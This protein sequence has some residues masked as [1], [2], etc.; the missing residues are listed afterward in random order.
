MKPIKVDLSGEFKKIEIHPLADLHIGDTHC[1]FK[2]ILDELEYI[3]KTPN[4]YCILD[5]DLMNTAIKNSVSDCYSESISPMEQIKHC[6]SIFEPIK[7][8]ILAVC[9][10]NHEARVYRETSLDMTELFCSQLGIVDRYSSSTAL[11][12]IRFGKDIKHNRKMCYT[13]YMTHGNGGG[14]KE[15]GKINRLADLANI[16]DA[17]IYVMAHTH[18]PAAFRNT[19]YRADPRNSDVTNCEH[20]FVNTASW[21]EYSG[22][23]GDTMGFKPTS[24]INPVI[25]LDGAQKSARAVI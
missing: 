12:Y 14:R 4:A 17:D 3:K 7:D 24:N 6:V 16:V 8:K 11:V 1:E 25:I 19:F 10:G 15:G 23:Y 13:L 21:L 2:R 20:L 18:S 9:G 22:S 5:G